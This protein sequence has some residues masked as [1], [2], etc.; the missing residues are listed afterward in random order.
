[1]ADRWLILAVLFLA[2]TAMAYQFQ[3]VVSAGP[4]IVDAFEIDFARLGTLIGLYMLPGIVIA[5]PGGVLGQRFGDKRIV[6]LGLALMAIG[7]GL[8]AADSFLA[9]TSGRLL[10]GVGAV[11]I[12]VLI[13]KM[14]AD[15]FA[16]QEIVVAMGILIASWPL[17][18]ALGLVSFP[19]IAAYGWKAVMLTSGGVAVACLL[20]VWLVYRD[21]PQLPARP[22]TLR[23][24]LTAREWGLIVIL[25]LIW[26]G[27]NAGYVV[28]IGFLPEQF[29][30][31]GFTLSEASQL[32]SLLGWV[33]IPSVPLAGFLAE[34][35]NRPIVLMTSSLLITAL[36][37]M[38]LP[39]ANS[40]FVVFS[41]IVLVIGVPAGLIMAL[42]AEVLPQEKRSAGMG[43]FYT[44]HYASMAVLPA[45]AGVIRDHTNSPTAPILFVG[46]LMAIAAAA[47]V[48]VRPLLPLAR[49][50]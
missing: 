17:G 40:P 30:R 20:L 25:G 16:G 46:A 24:D 19:P 37:T 5:L 22:L 28:L 10:S 13:T 42:P 29:T 15:W 6:L 31:Q 43:V 18:L 36:A 47:L 38:A 49:A 39:F 32:V 33:L 34:R 21:P 23:I 12:N 48:G 7:G 4:F 44:C 1:M 45:L 3:S 27:Y 35:V 14:V 41:V 11:I 2:R 9:V 26:G 8:M 50:S